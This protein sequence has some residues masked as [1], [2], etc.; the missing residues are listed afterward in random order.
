MADAHLKH[1]VFDELQYMRHFYYSLSYS[2][3]SFV[4]SGTKMYWES[5]CS[6]SYKGKFT[7]NII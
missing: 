4:A 3:H 7:K 1:K 2:C 6:L 5:Y